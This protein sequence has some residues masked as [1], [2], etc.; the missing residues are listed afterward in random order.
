MLAPEACFTL[1][2]G[3]GKSS[4]GKIV[5]YGREM[6]YSAPVKFYIFLKTRQLYLPY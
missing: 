4:F 5:F 2:R 1:R 6:L 3:K